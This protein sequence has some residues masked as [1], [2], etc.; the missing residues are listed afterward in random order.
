MET[1]LMGDGGQVRSQTSGLGALC[2]M[3]GILGAASGIYLAVVEPV[4]A[5][6]RFSFPLTAGGF[7][8]I[9]IWFFL[10]HVG[11]MAGSTGAWR[12]GAF[13]SSRSG[14][15]GYHVGLWGM[16]L[17]AVTELFAIGAR[18]AAYPSS[19]TAPLDVLYGVSSFA[20]GIGWIMGGMAA[21]RNGGWPG[22]PGGIML[23]IGIY[24]FIP[25]TPAIAAGFL[26]ARLSISM[27]MLL[28]AALGYA[29][30]REE[31]A[32]DVGAGKAPRPRG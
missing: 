10:Q 18:N 13:G 11:L 21:R 14:R 16:L 30:M 1:K 23:A 22:W 27:W 4:V 17:L 2:V 28:F 12:A 15:W 6:D 7:T 20:I 5:D 24:V 9:Q 31:S 29:I 25:M 26:P 19:E 8:A 32:P 3:S